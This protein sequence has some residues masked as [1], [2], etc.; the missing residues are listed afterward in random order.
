MEDKDPSHKAWTQKQPQAWGSDENL[1]QTNKT[2][3][4]DAFPFRYKMMGKQIPIAQSAW[5]CLLAQFHLLPKGP[6]EEEY[7]YSHPMA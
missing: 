5:F 6:S 3:C 2:L 1:D 4:K 7:L